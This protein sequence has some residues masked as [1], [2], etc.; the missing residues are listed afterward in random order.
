MTVVT[1]Y[2]PS[3]CSA[4]TQLISWLIHKINVVQVD[5]NNECKQVIIMDNYA[6]YAYVQ[7]ELW[8]LRNRNYRRGKLELWKHVNNFG[9][10]I[11]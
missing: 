9:Y 11:F 5:M 4:T 2:M 1:C 6:N 10:K 8:V 7:S 3:Q